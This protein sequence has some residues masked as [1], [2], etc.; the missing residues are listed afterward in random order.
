MIELKSGKEFREYFKKDFSTRCVEKYGR[1][2][3]ELALV[4]LYDVLATTIRD[5]AN[6]DS[7]ICK[8]ITKKEGKKQLIYFSM[9]FLVGRQLTTNLYN[10]GLL[11]DVRTS[12]KELGIDCDKLREQEPDAGLGNGGLGRL[13]SLHRIRGHRLSSADDSEILSNQSDRLQDDFGK[14]M[15]LLDTLPS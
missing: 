8:D 15:M 3:S 14:A 10:L 13:L 11:E 7:K 12:L 5:Y 6:V 4:D 9:E 2:P 1:D